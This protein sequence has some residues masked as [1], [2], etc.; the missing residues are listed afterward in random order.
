MK[1]KFHAM[2]S[3][4]LVDVL[5]EELVA[6][7]F[8]ELERVFSGVQFTSDWSG[9]YRANL[10]LRSA[11]RVTL[12]ILQFKAR[13][14]KEL[15]DKVLEHDFTQYIDADKTIAVDSMVKKSV[16]KDQR[17]FT[18][19]IKDAIVDQFRDKFGVRPNVAKERPDLKI[20]ARTTD[21]DVYL[22]IDTSGDPL[23]MRGYR[24]TALEAPLKEHLAA[25]LILLTGW[26][27]NMN[28]TIVDPMCG[29]GTF[30]IEAALMA[31]NIAPGVLRKRFSFQSFKSFDDGAWNQVVEQALEKEI[32]EPEVKFYG[33]DKD[34]RAIKISKENAVSAGVDHLIEW[35]KCAIDFLEPP[36]ETGMIIINP[37][38][39]E[40]LG[41]TEQLKDVYKDMA[42]ILKSK[43]KGWTCFMLSG[44]AELTGALKMKANQKHLIMNGPIE[45]RFLEYKVF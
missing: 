11:T 32:E 37:P 8:D 44:N 3:Q 13:T 9:C 23:F 31:S 7:G 15:Y 4:G 35:Q 30:L 24:K 39:G 6:L 40:R 22:S 1:Y 43:F 27:K 12:P 38:Y 21:D 10:N 17:F 29:S 33:F 20:M 34:K 14:D 18:L 19:K 45:C 41:V 16:F 25:G 36:T 26:Q 5:F 42:Y 2:T 28:V